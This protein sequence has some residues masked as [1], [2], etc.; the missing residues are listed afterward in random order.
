MRNTGLILL[1]VESEMYGFNNPWTRIERDKNKKIQKN[2]KIHENPWISGLSNA[3]L[4]F[5]EFIRVGLSGRNM[6]RFLKKK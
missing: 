4:Y 6:L 3:P 1:L 5:F 2:R